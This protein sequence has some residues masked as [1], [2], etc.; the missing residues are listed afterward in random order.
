MSYH[1]KGRDLIALQLS[2]EPDEWIAEQMSHCREKPPKALCLVD[3]ILRSR[4]LLRTADEFT[5]IFAFTEEELEKE[6]EIG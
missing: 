6:R 3:L 5:K 4:N 2:Y 1:T